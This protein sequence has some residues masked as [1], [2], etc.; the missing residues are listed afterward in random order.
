[1]GIIILGMVHLSVIVARVVAVAASLGLWIWT[2]ALLG[3]RTAPTIGADGA[4]CDGIH[5]LTA[6]IHA[7]LLKYPERADALLIS[8]SLVID[9]LG[10][11]VLGLAIFGRTI[12]PFLGLFI[13]FA[14][15]QFCQAFCPLPPPPGMI[16]RDPGFPT[17]L[18]TYGTANDLFFSGHTAI[19]VYGAV[20]LGGSLGPIGMVL[21]GIIIGFEVSVVLLL[22]AHYTMDV[23]TGA[24]T[25]LYVHRLAADWAPVVDRWIA[26]V[27]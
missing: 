17:L 9:L 7:R 21:G 15:R 27:T 25:A 1:M 2:Q 6:R 14:L 20:V 8:S 24:I 4:I 3:R 5:Q 22:R 19:A 10:F 13:L 18:V 16:W 23:F 11:Y 12:E 26:H